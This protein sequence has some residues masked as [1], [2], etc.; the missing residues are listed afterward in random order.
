MKWWWLVLIQFMDRNNCRNC[1][2]TILK[3]FTQ[4]NGKLIR[5]DHLIRSIL[6]K[7]QSMMKLVKNLWKQCKLKELTSF[8]IEMKSEKR[9]W[10]R[11]LEL[12]HFQSTKE[13]SLLIDQLPQRK[14]KRP[15]QSRRTI[16]S[17]LKNSQRLTLN[18]FKRN[19]ILVNHYMSRL[20][21]SFS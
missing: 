11:L 14:R 19:L 9:Q 16:C 3:S 20:K 10:I 6:L 21:I 4:K 18:E 12:T 17:R 2:N 7:V 15:D 8:E 1:L 5:E 13:R